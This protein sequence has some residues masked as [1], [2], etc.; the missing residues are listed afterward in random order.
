MFAVS[1]YF[2]SREVYEKQEDGRMKSYWNPCRVIG[3]TNN[4]DGEAAYV[5]EYV[6]GGIT[7]IETETCLKRNEPGSPL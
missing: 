3:V 7:Y 1:P 5:V 6:Q 4:E 2:A